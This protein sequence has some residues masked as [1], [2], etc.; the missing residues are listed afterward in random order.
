[1]TAKR[2]SPADP[3]LQD[4]DVLSSDLERMQLDLLTARSELQSLTSV[5]DQQALRVAELETELSATR[6]QS[7]A[8][9]SDASMDILMKAA[10]MLSV[11]QFMADQPMDTSIGHSGVIDLNTFDQW[12]SMKRSEFLR[13]E[14]QLELAERKD[15]VLYEWV[16]SH[17]A[18]FSEA[19]SNF[20]NAHLQEPGLATKDH[21]AGPTTRSTLH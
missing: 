1:M 3:A 15:D 8:L 16:T 2:Y 11:C 6:K 19:M 9:G 10:G 20:K 17:E 13:L 18:T 4:R 12:L 21:R 5:C 7:I 14:V